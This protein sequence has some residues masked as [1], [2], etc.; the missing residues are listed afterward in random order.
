L[1]AKQQPSVELIK[2]REEQIDS[3]LAASVG[4]LEVTSTGQVLVR[5]L[6]AMTF[7][8]INVAYPLD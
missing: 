6:A 3:S 2:R 7:V 8:S 5:P 4:F 1:A